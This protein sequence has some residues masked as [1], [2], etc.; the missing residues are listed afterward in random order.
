MLVA[1]PPKK[2]RRAPCELTPDMVIENLVTKR[3]VYKLTQMKIIEHRGVGIK[4][5]TGT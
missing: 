1:P 4:Q 3:S 5:N 2:I